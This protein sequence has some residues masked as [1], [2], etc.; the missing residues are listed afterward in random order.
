MTATD[1]RPAPRRAATD[2]PLPA[3]NGS[4]LR[5]LLMGVRFALTG[6]REAWVRT[7][8]TAVGV[9]LGVSVL[10]LASSVPGAM[11]RRDVRNEARSEFN[12]AVDGG[13][14]TDRSLLVR[15][16]DTTFRD[17]EVRGRLLKPEGPRA[18]LPPGLDAFPAHG[19]M[20]VSPA[21]RELLDSDGTKLLSGR[22][23][24]EITATVGTEGLSG[25]GEL[26]FYAGH[27]RL[28]TD[29]GAGHAMRID[30]FG[31]QATADPLDPVLMLLVLIILVVLLMPVAV[32]VAASV[33]F[34]GERRDRR[35][36]ALRLVGADARMTRR[37]AAGEAVA[38]SLLGLAVGAVM[39]FLGRQLAN[40][41]TIEQVSVF[42]ED[43][44]PGPLLAALVVLAVPLAS[45]AVTLLALRGVVIEPLGVVR[46]ARPR[47][48]RLLWRLLP[49]IG[50]VALLA[51]LIAQGTADYF[52]TY[53]VVCG[54]VLLLLGVTSLLPW[55]VESVVGRLGGG[56]VS[57][58]LAVR[59]L[60]L[61]G[62]AAA[63]AMNG[64]AVAVAGAVALQMLFAGVDNDYIQVAEKDLRRAE[65][66][67]RTPRSVPPAEVR[68]ALA[69][70]PGVR[71]ASAIGTGLV[72]PR[73][74]AD[75][76]DPMELAVGDCAT[77]RKVADLPSCRDGDVFR[78]LSDRQAS[79]APR[80]HAEP[81][82]TLYVDAG[83]AGAAAADTRWRL[84][85]EVKDARPLPDPVGYERDGLLATPGAFPEERARQLGGQVFVGVD[86]GALDARDRVRTTVA[87]LSPFH[88]VSDHYGVAVNDQF[89]DVR[90]GLFVGATCVLLLI[91]ASLLVSQVERLRERKKLLASLVAFGTR[92]RTLVWSVLWQTAVPV[93][94]ALVLALGVGLLL[95][96]VLL[97][98]VQTT[99]AVPWAVVGAMTGVAGLVVL[100]VTAL[101]MP[102]LL[103]LMRPEGLRTE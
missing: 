84:P 11:D 46:T 5:D 30:A 42:P 25:P 83:G 80:K 96:T 98:V 58:Q 86:E 4:A 33:R 64:V 75:G 90:K 100:L 47:R 53:V 34:G 41:M 38:G 37:V 92:R 24:Y 82:A 9:G 88:Q 14:P 10:L 72:T 43:L 57:W 60:Q 2:S 77:L 21:L 17:M 40:V 59:R 35:L 51:P 65:M 23:P 67:V 71:F 91:G 44:A 99:P 20:A 79:N 103:R 89:A 8:L 85:A 45:V 31:T 16:A 50:G 101:T 66:D 22:I 29:G 13:R 18:P 15:A 28:N 3:P 61:S 76:E 81:H 52:N 70:L 7:L 93:V 19:E 49:L 69:G 63:Q 68:E 54:A 102:V 56:P 74:A 94:L 32:F 48:R 78:L 39:F 1:T 73:P 62:G 27:D 95:G 26:V 87:A 12:H 36:A 6:G 97:F 55:V